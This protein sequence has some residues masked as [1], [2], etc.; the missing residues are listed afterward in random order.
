MRLFVWLYGCLCCCLFV[1]RME[2]AYACS[3][4]C[5]ADGITTS[6]NSGSLGSRGSA[7]ANVLFGRNA[8][9]Q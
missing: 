5:T 7:M 9:E 6:M 4:T 2:I 1:C 8:D 3:L